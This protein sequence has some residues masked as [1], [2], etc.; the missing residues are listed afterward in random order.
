MSELPNLDPGEQILW[1]GKPG[2]PAGFQQTFLDYLKLL[3]PVIVI[4][5]L[6]HI[7]TLLQ[8]LTMCLAL[9][10]GLVGVAALLASLDALS[11]R[12]LECAIT[13][14]RIMIFGKSN[15]EILFSDLV[16]VRYSGSGETGFLIFKSETTSISFMGLENVGAIM[17]SLPPNVAQAARDSSRSM[18][19]ACVSF[20]T[21]SN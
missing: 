14:K 8:D 5:F 16:K 6:A 19:P 3:S 11:D 9:T 10:A 12:G 15:K 20:K 18:L 7:Q 2:Q 4:M 13:D 17:Q 21:V 1:Q